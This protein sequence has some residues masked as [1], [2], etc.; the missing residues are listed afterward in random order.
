MSELWLAWRNTAV[1]ILGLVVAGGSLVGG[2]SSR[3][4]T[5]T[6]KAGGQPEAE[7]RG[8]PC[9]A[10][11]STQRSAVAGA[12]L[13]L[14]DLAA[15]TPAAPSASAPDDVA[16]I[17]AIEAYDG[18]PHWMGAQ[19]SASAWE[20][21]FRETLGIPRGRVLRLHP[22]DADADAIRVAVRQA[23]WLG[24]PG[25]RLWLVFLGALAPAPDGG[26]PVLCGRSALWHSDALPWNQQVF[27]YSQV[28][29]KLDRSAAQPIVILDALADPRLQPGQRWVPPP[30]A[31]PPLSLPH[32][33]KALVLM[34][35]VSH[36]AES[37][38]PGTA[39]PALSYLALGGLRGWADANGDGSVTA[40]E[41]MELYQSEVRA[42]GVAQSGGV[43]A[44]LDGDPG[45]VLA[46][47]H[48]A[49]P[50]LVSPAG[51]VANGV[52]TLFNPLGAVLPELPQ[53]K[54]TAPGQLD[55]RASECRRGLDYGEERPPDIGAWMQFGAVSKYCP[56]GTNVDLWRVAWRGIA[57]PCDH[58]GREAHDIYE[59][60]LGY[61]AQQ[62]RLMVSLGGD[63]ERLDRAMHAV[64]G[65][66]VQQASLLGAFEQRYPMLS[67][68]G[69]RE[70]LER[71]CRRWT[72]D[73]GGHRPRAASDLMW[74]VIPGGLLERGRP[75]EELDLPSEMAGDDSGRHQ[76][77]PPVREQRV[78][79]PQGPSQW[80][81]LPSFE[82]L[83]T[84][85]TVAEYRRCVRHGPCRPPD[86]PPGSEFATFARTDREDHPVNY[87]DWTRAQE[88]CTWV[89]GRLPSEAEW[90]W[91]ASS[92][93]T[94]YARGC[95]QI[96]KYEPEPDPIEGPHDADPCGSLE[97]GTSA[98]CSRPAGSSAQ[99]ICD[100]SGNV[101]EWMADTRHPLYCGA[102]TDGS[103]WIDPADPARI[104]RGGSW[105]D[106]EH[107]E[108]LAVQQT[109]RD[110][111]I[112]FR[113]ARDL[114]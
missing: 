7:S 112:G 21:Y 41:V 65:S 108:R 61:Q 6:P 5:S 25:A 31:V 109:V 56:A 49:G 40:G 69:L 99:G 55:P 74:T 79:L 12:P 105:R 54:R 101:W 38:L 9:L 80:V 29:Q 100:L 92:R 81:L 32:S 78:H 24:R 34:R 15:A 103:A 19:Q 42:L 48:E 58:G 23:A 83:R 8:S 39:S 1:A 35:L 97:A 89:G 2:C 91:A 86:A 73:E 11:M 13:A 26:E 50:P 22:L 44:R 14:P 17:I 53:L 46:H 84:E 64:H 62:A 106:A 18:G 107:L 43:L 37:L 72:D 82:L 27:P 96:V 45:T 67:E 93:S 70:R 75:A 60:L 30:Q 57:D 36:G 51:V 111:D 85:V 3:M 68:L 110:A 16:L 114:P 104:L 66:R 95:A 88:Y 94:R 102:P 47:G 90:E 113:C 77:S 28:L 76:F 20:R 4:P 98:V 33:G 52:E 10:A 63:W 71:D 87:V 59:R